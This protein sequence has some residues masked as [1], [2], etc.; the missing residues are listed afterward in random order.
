MG[1]V[2]LIDALER[3]KNCFNSYPMDRLALVGAVAAFEDKEYFDNCRKKVIASRERLAQ[4]LVALGFVVL[5]SAA[6][7]VF[8]RHPKRD[9]AALAAFLRNE[10]VLVRHFNLPRIDQFLRITVGTDE[11]CDALITALRKAL[12]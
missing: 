9:G 2:G 8:A 6:N 10:A 12:A 1:D 3:I 7:F 5:P 11:Q 4:A